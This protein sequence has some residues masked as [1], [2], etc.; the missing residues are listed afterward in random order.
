MVARS[1]N[2]SKRNSS[3]SSTFALVYQNLF[4]KTNNNG[5][6]RDSKGNAAFVGREVSDDEDVV[7]LMAKVRKI[8]PTSPNPAVHVPSLDSNKQTC[9]ESYTNVA[10]HETSLL[11]D[12]MP[13]SDTHSKWHIDS[14]ASSHMACDKSNFKDYKEVSTPSAVL[15]DKSVAKAAGKGTVELT[16]NVS[17][18][19]TKCRLEDVMHIPTFGFNLLSVS[20]LCKKGLKV[21][22]EGETCRI[23]KKN[24]I[25][26]TGHLEGDLFVLDTLDTPADQH[27]HDADLKLWHERLAHVSSDGITQ[28]ARN[29]VVKGLENLKST[30]RDEKMC[31]LSI[32]QRSP[33]PIPKAK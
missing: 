11:S 25:V 16:L 33:T 12:T 23:F 28:M 14:G 26:A 1:S 6:N 19:D 31:C 9:F 18:K 20:A 10:S 21:E 24:T 30:K 3:K 4:F 8:V 13:S 15:G 32:R 7:C 29:N 17:G 2:R 27:A 5:N 22:F